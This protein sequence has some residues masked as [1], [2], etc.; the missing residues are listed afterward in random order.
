MQD[1]TAP[2]NG[3]KRTLRDE[4]LEE[5]RYEKGLAAP[6]ITDA[7]LAACTKQN[8]YRPTLSLVRLYGAILLILWATWALGGGWWLVPA[9][10][11]IG[12]LQ[13]G[14]SI[15]L[16]DAVHGLLFPNRYANEIIGALLLSYPIG[17]SFDY[18]P[19]HFSH[20][21]HLG[22][23]GDPDLV[24]YRD[25][26]ATRGRLVRKLLIDFSGLGAF[27]QFVE[28]NT[29]FVATKKSRHTLVIALVQGLLFLL[30]FAAGYPLAYFVLWLLPLVTVAKGLAQ[31]RNLAEHLVR[32]GRES[33]GPGRLRTF[34]SNPI[35]R[36]FIAPLNFNYHAEHHWFP[37]VPYYNL[38]K[39]RAFLMK[40]PAYAHLAEW[41]SSYMAALGRA[42]A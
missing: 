23:P 30:F 5:A 16:H 15:L 10:I 37:Q 31:M 4:I 28:M 40:D 38:P 27:M 18:R 8:S 41:C 24:N 3:A 22:S 1:G 2:R 35:E 6:A 12:A 26:P 36:F 42:V 34:K 32:E 17:F 33:S 19:T 29:E 13:H 14:I 39:L 21:K 9:F 25:F 20:H 7:A 11:L